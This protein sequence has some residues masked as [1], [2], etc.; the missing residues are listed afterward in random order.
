MLYI[1][2]TMTD[3]HEEGDK[4]DVDSTCDEKTDAAERD[5]TKPKTYSRDA[6]YE[7][8]KHKFK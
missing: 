1:V 2:I 3:W 8:N 6:G 4:G 5:A 7:W